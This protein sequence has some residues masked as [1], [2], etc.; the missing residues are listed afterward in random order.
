MWKRTAV[1]SIPIAA[2][3]AGGC[4]T[5]AQLKTSVDQA[6]STAEE[7]KQMAA[8][9][10]AA[11]AQAQADANAAKEMASQAQRDA[12]DAKAAA[13]AASQ[14]ADRMFEKAVSK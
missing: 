13:A 2:L 11:A 3:L 4:A 5:D 6:Q 9:A 1:L 14:K 8:A 10:K 7:A 12:A